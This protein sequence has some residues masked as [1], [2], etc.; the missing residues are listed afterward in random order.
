MFF[1]GWHCF[2]C[3]WN[4]MVVTAAMFNFPALRVLVTIIPVAFTFNV[5]QLLCWMLL[6]VFVFGWRNYAVCAV[7]SVSW[8][9]HTFS[10]SKSITIN[11][12]Y[13]NS[14]LFPFPGV[15][16]NYIGCPRK[17]RTNFLLNSWF[18]KSNCL[19]WF[20][21][22]VRY[23]AI[24]VLS[25]KLFCPIWSKVS[26]SIFIL[27]SALEELWKDF[28]WFRF[29]TDSSPL[30][31]SFW[32]DQLDVPWMDMVPSFFEGLPWRM[33]LGFSFISSSDNLRRLI[34]CVVLAWDHAADKDLWLR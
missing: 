7:L 32:L 3:C 31:P 30:S 12:A 14:K 11:G 5:Y 29:W 33:V 1:A 24:R 6:A 27:P 15:A 21:D 10:P 9:R 4:R 16:V 23:T 26:L 34:V 13:E 18:G 22:G 2:V 8:H 28:L 19:V 20:F 17:H 25:R